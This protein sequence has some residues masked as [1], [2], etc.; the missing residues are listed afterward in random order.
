MYSET[1]GGLDATL[2]QSVSLTEQ[3]DQDEEE[4]KTQ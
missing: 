3:H 2:M 1:A 4:K